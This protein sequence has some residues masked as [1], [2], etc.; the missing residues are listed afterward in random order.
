MEKTVDSEK[1][2]DN[3][4]W[5]EV[6]LGDIL[7]FRR[8]H[9][10]PKKN[11]I[12]GDYPV[13]G[14]NGV[15]GYHN[16]Y[17][18]NSPCITIGRSGNV[19]NPHI[20]RQNCWAHNTT[21]YIDDFKNNS[22]EF[23]Y[24]L[25]KTLNL[26]N[27]GGGSAVPTLN[28]NHIHPIE[29]N[30]PKNIKE[31]QKIASILKS[32]DDKIELNNQ[33]N[34]TLEEMA[35]C[36]FKEWFVEF[37]FPNEE[38]VPYKD[39]GGEMVELGEVCDIEKG[40]SYKGKHLVDEGIPMVNLGSVMPGGGYR[41]DKIKF[42]DGDFKERHQVFPGDII[43]ANTDMTQDRVIL[44]SPF[45]VPRF[46]GSKIIFTHHLFS[47]TNFKISKSYIYNYLKDKK[48]REM[49]ESCATGT[50]V[51]ALPKKDVLTIG[52]M[53]PKNDILLAFDK[54]ISEILKKQEQISEENQT[55]IKLRD[56]LLPKLMSGEVRV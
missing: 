37:N 55:L 45:I 39:N 26:G 27:Y 5:K 41:E 3:R 24:Y 10:L 2:T 8:G 51:L 22:P 47:V 53:I 40:L 15:I 56:E 11:M 17:T 30:F 23:I 20:I 19:G 42:Y 36:I 54:I 43:I 6:R 44:G 31:Q 1:L 13:V 50:T 46:L 14:S 7:N 32:L 18:T 25:L 48:F 52:I 33:M 49:A 29:I 9:D 21:L 34:Q 16:E 28:R 35:Q 4:E 38:G 12:H